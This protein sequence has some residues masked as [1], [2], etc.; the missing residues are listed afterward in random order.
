MTPLPSGAVPG[1]PVDPTPDLSRLETR[2]RLSQSAINGFFAIMDKWQLPI[3]Q[4]G[5]LLGGVPRSTVFK[6]KIVAGTLRQDELTRI[7]LHRW[8][9]RGAAQPSS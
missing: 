7:S 1:C 6:L 2:K 8:D 9:L 5:E 4:A 3:E